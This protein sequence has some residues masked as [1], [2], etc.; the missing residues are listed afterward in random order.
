MVPSSKERARRTVTFETKCYE[1]DWEFVLAEGHL[2]RVIA[3][4]DHRFDHKVLFLNNFSDYSAAIRASR[5]LVAEG[6]IDEYVVVADHAKDTLRSL[7]IE[8]ASFRGGYHYSIAEL[9]GIARCETD[10]LLHFASDA[11]MDG[12]GS[13]WISNA[14]DMLEEHPDLFVA[15]PTWNRRYDEAEHE[16]SAS[17]DEWFF[18]YGFS[19][20][21]YL[22]DPKRLRGPIYNEKHAASER[23]PAYGGELFE[24]RVDAYMRNH[25]LR[26]I[27]SRRVS[28]VHRNWPR[29]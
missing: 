4:C 25:S 22:L 7:G 29:I 23:Y 21:C 15:N 26:R 18:S 8:E 3:E 20:Q 17:N 13:P 10:Y 6:V 2:R 5:Q 1:R 11:R 24:K 12:A 28:Y 19:D 27:T 14:I 9:V 16:A